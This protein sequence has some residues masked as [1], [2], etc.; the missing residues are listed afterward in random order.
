MKIITGLIMLSL[1]SF[2]ASASSVSFGDIA[3]GIIV[4][5]NNDRNNSNYDDYRPGHRDDRNDRDYGR[6]SRPGYGTQVTC[7]ARDRGHEEHR[8]HRSCGECLR[9]HGQCIETCAVNY[10]VCRAEGED[11]YG[12]RAS[13][14]GHAQS[15]YESQRNALYSCERDRRFRN[16]RVVSCSNSSETVSRRRC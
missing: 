1:I 15:Q 4:A 12:R 11:R 8:N 10:T 9:K 7:S 16:C 5:A 2:G 14:E 6:P 3:K 13:F